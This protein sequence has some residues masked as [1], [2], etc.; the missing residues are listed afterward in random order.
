MATA[1]PPSPLF[2]SC[3]DPRLEPEAWLAHKL[4]ASWDWLKPDYDAILYSRVKR[5]D[6]LRKAPGGLQAAKGMY[7][8]PWGFYDF[9]FDW[10]TILDPRLAAWGKDT[11]VPFVLFP[12]QVEFL[13]WMQRL[14]T[15]PAENR[16]GKGNV[17][18]TRGCGAS[19]LGC[20]FSLWYWL[21]RPNSHIGLGSNLER[22]VFDSD[23]PKALFWKI[24]NGLR[25]LPEEFLPAGFQFGK[26]LMKGSGAG[27][28]IN[29][30]NGSTINGDAG[31]AIGRGDR[32]LFYIID[33]HA[34]LQYPVAAE[35]ALQK[36]TNTLIRIS[37]EKRDCLFH[38]QVVGLKATNP[39]NLFEYDWWD[40][41]R[42]SQELFDREKAEA[43]AQGMGDIFRVEVERDPDSVL[44]DTFIPKSLLEEAA[45][46]MPVPYGP[47]VIAV[48]VAAMGNDSSVVSWRR[49]L[50]QSALRKFEKSSDDGQ[51]LAA[52]VMFLAEEILHQGVP[53]GAVVY[54]LEGSGYAL[55]S[56][57]SG[58]PLRS[59]LRPTH[60]GKKLSNGRHYNVRA[61]GWDLWRK[62]LEEGAGV[63]NDRALIHLGSALKY[64]WRESGGKKLLLL[65]DK[66]AFKKRMAADPTNPMGG[67]SPDEADNCALAWLPVE[68]ADFGL[69]D[70]L[71]AAGR[72][73]EDE[74]EDVGGWGWVAA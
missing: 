28:L 5:L 42:M 7:G 31:P 69:V 3:P 52:E 10:G 12:R 46:R 51:Q 17:S 70:Y 57:L 71:R 23:N 27:K 72:V 59:V 61:Q 74:E 39:D 56:V 43:E 26:H 65:E 37:T 13:T 64:E 62:A 73:G 18:K 9:L 66:K 63:P 33:E 35:A 44:V 47:A 16:S 60:P 55:H 14:V 53:L 1:F 21:F 22:S 20:F 40:D 49:G 32:R 19:T 24:E 15:F 58:G 41:P 2:S 38:T 6:F 8:S 36:T 68:M 30:E 45:K 48:D 25:G 4:P 34:S 50:W 11:E 29:P 67:P 54:E